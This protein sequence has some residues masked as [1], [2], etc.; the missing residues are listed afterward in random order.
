MKSLPD[1]T[2]NSSGFTHRQA[3]TIIVGLMLSVF[4]AALN[5]TVVATALP[6]IAADLQGSSH[7]TWIIAIYL[8]TSTAATP[9]YGKLSDMYGRRGLLE[10]SLIGFILASI[11][12][13]LATSMAQLIAFRALQGLGG[14]GLQALTLSIMGDIASPRERGRYQS[15]IAATFGVASIIGPALGGFLAEE[16]SWR[17]AF[18]LNVPVGIA[19]L[20]AARRT[21]QGL[22]GR[23]VGHRIDY[24]GALL[25]MATICCVLLLTT[26]G[27]ND[28]P[29]SSPV[30]L[31][32]AFGSF[33]LLGLTILQERRA[34][35]PIISPLFFRIP[36]FLVM[37]GVT[38]ISSGTIIGSIIFMP[39]YLQI[40]HAQQATASGVMLIPFT[41]ASLFGSVACGWLTVATGRYRFLAVWGQALAALSFLGLA[42]APGLVPLWAVAMALLGIGL[43]TGLVSPAISLA[44]QNAVEARDIGAASAA[45]ISFRSIGGS[46]GVALFGAVVL[47]AMNGLVGQ[48]PGLEPGQGAGIALLRAGSGALT[49]VE[50]TARQALSAALVSAFD[51]LFY[52]A[53]ILNLLAVAILLLAKELPL[54]TQ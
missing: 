39:I 10:V 13:A 6:R 23:R 21:M 48:M 35:E 20:V 45:L 16:L 15:Y 1:T 52:M 43:G 41:A 44:V 12:C 4:L 9:I 50:P 53:G 2:L 51:V 34:R 25:I 11:L 18:W 14:G 19:A 46:I 33:A 49:L 37:N 27:G 38:M 3:V 31:A 32:L 24:L 40:V 30:I 28:V 17:W 22:V 26:M 47:A 5:Q 29:W 8:L 42:L 7:L 36:V 54:R